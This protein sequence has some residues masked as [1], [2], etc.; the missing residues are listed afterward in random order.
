MAVRAAVIRAILCSSICLTWGAVRAEPIVSCAN[1]AIVIEADEE[2]A[3]RI[4]TNAQTAIRQLASCNLSVP[5]PIRISV[6]T[7]LPPNCMASYHCGEAHIELLDPDEF[8]AL[9]SAESAF[10]SVSA[11]SYFASA[12]RHELVHAAL[13]G[14]PCDVENCPV[15]QEYLAYGLQI[16]F[17]PETDREAFESAMTF[18]RPIMKNDIS[19]ELMIIDP[20]LFAQISWR[21]LSKKDEPCDFVKQVAQGEV[22]FDHSRT[23]YEYGYGD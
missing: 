6:A 4:C 7:E 12:L 14:M 3:Q 17:L 5:A 9:V 18:E 8:S 21:H 15:A 10:A 13:D 23:F 19:L 20:E 22:R 11:G 1:G 16:M 2:T